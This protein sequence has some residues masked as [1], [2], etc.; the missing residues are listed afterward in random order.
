MESLY[1]RGADCQGILSARSRTPRRDAN[2]PL[3]AVRRINLTRE[4]RDVSPPSTPLRKFR[5]R[6]PRFSFQ[7]SSA[8]ERRAREI[9]PPVRR[10][11]RSRINTER[12][13]KAGAFKPLRSR[14]ETSN[15]VGHYDVPRAG[16][17]HTKM[18]SS[19]SRR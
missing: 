11:H 8:L 14:T 10:S 13:L 7:A 6:P 3:A 17:F 4:Q 1:R 19:R 18:S 9:L 2:R 15:E 12:E 16:F 5:S